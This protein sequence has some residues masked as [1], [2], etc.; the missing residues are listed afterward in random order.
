M[1]NKKKKSYK[2]IRPTIKRVSEI[3]TN[4]YSKRF[5]DKKVLREKAKEVVIGLKKTGES[6]TI[7]NV[8]SF[9]RIKKSKFIAK[10]PYEMSSVQNYF[11]LVQYPN[12]ILTQVDPR[13]TIISKVSPPNLP[14]IKGLTE[15]DYDEYFADF[16]NHCNEL[17]SLSEEGRYEQDW[18]VTTR[19]ID[20]KRNIFEIISCSGEDE[21]G[22]VVEFDYGFD[23]NKPKRVPKESI[24]TDDKPPE[25]EKEKPKEDIKEKDV[26]K[27]DDKKE[28]TKQQ[29]I[30]LISDIRE[31][32]R[33]GLISK[34]D[35]VQIVK[36]LASKLKKGGNLD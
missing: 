28:N 20:E 26:E 24:T 22:N 10:L 25:K 23:R 36:E 15:I 33:E 5:S 6:A 8:L 4:F 14:P 3:L 17:A 13:I 29:I 1:A 27:V 34:E 12:L 30:K 32:F 19:L 9:V 18:F 2:K 35:Y 31:D 16:V 7:K 21:N 11:I